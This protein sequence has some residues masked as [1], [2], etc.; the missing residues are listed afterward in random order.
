VKIAKAGDGWRVTCLDPA[1]RRV[2]VMTFTTRAEAQDYVDDL[3]DD[4]HAALRER[5]YFR[6][7]FC[8]AGLD[9]DHRDGGEAWR[10]TSV[11]G[12]NDKE[13]NG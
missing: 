8:N 10:F 4:F 7:F 3:E 13:A 6:G 9:K 2:L 12:D 5:R 11:L 1:S